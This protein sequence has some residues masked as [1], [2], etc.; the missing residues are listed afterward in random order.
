MQYHDTLETCHHNALLQ[1]GLRIICALPCIYSTL[2][3]VHVICGQRPKSKKA[4]AP[5]IFAIRK[6]GGLGGAWCHHHP[7]RGGRI[8]LKYFKGILPPWQPLG[9]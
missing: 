8:A 1:A 9:W 6:T 7:F 3:Y 2:L 5:L 4:K